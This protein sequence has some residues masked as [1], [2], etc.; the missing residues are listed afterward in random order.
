MYS[1]WW[2]KPSSATLSSMMK[3]S[4]HLY[5]LTLYV[6]TELMQSDL[7]KIIVSPQPLTADHIKVFLYQILRGLKFLHSARILHRDIKPGNLLVNSNCVLKICDF[8]L[9]RVEEK[10]PQAHMTQ[11]VVTQYY[12]APELLMAA[13]HYTSAVD[14]WSVG[15]ILAELLSRKILFQAQTPVLQLD[16]IT[17][18]LGSPSPDELRHVCEGARLHILNGKSKPV[19]TGTLY[20]L[21]PQVT[22]EAVHLLCQM[23]TINPDKRVT[24]AQALTHPYLSEGRLRYHSCMCTCCSGVG[25]QRKFAI[26]LEPVAPRPLDPNFDSG[27]THVRQVR[28]TLHRFIIDYCE[29]TQRT[30]L[31]INPS[32]AAFKLFARSSSSATYLLNC[33]QRLEPA[34]SP[35]TLRLITTWT[36]PALRAVQFSELLSCGDWDRWYT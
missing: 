27:F 36:C 18:L 3:E 30:P 12:R 13:T 29:K 17:D 2:R 6:I 24:C 11:E 8:G 20:N 19:A 9:A 35:E 34:T 31:C 21:S 5:H 22:P 4:F 16:L 1:K 7:H 26:E 23:L 10:D 25:G 28:E 14:I 32:S 33:F 15:C